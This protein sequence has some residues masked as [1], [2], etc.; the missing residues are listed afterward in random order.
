MSDA[1]E[2]SDELL[3]LTSIYDSS[4]FTSQTNNEQLVTGTLK[5]S[6]ELPQPFHVK[7]AGKGEF[8]FC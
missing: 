8:L 3:V 6:V 7:L 4:V 2:Q 1:D 5:A